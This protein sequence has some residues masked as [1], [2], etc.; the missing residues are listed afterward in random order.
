MFRAICLGRSL[1]LRQPRFLP[2]GGD[3]STTW[4]H[5]RAWWS[6][7]YSRFQGCVTIREA[8]VECPRPHVPPLHLISTVSNIYAWMA[9][10]CAGYSRQ[11]SE[12]KSFFGQIF[13]HS[14]CYLCHLFTSSPLKY[15][16]DKRPY[17]TVDWIREDALPGLIFRDQP[18]WP[19]ACYDTCPSK[20]N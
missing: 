15:K 8:P 10:R 19:A 17:W 6:W 1:R 2:W 14:C 11:A 4:R 16:D 18:G 13:F 3:S 9:R 5:A 20:H 7:T 12:A